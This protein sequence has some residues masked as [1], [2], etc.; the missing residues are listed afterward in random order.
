MA[1]QIQAERFNCSTIQESRDSL[2]TLTSYEV[3]LSAR[4]T[5]DFQQ[6]VGGNA[7]L[8]PL[9]L[10][11]C[12]T[13]GTSA[14]AQNFRQRRQQQAEREHPSHAFRD[15][16]DPCILSSSQLCD[17]DARTLT[18]AGAAASAEHYYANWTQPYAEKPAQDRSSRQAER[19]AEPS[20]DR[21]ESLHSMTRQRACRLLGVTENSTREQI[22]TAYRQMASQWHPDRIE[23]M[24]QDELGIATEQ[25]AAI[26]EAYHLLRSQKPSSSRLN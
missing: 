20:G 22:K 21:L 15:L 8:D 6:L 3:E 9:F 5:G 7:E 23:P 17:L 25:M 10:V 16:Y 14:A 19:F 18:T 1:E 12:W 26:N 11:E 13:Y 4:L 24:N 2:S